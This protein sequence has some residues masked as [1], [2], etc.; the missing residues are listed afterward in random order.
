MVTAVFSES[1]DPLT[2]GTTWRGRLSS[3]RMAWFG[4][5]RAPS[6]RPDGHTE[7]G[8][9]GAETDSCVDSGANCGSCG[10][11]APSGMALLLCTGKAF[12]RVDLC[13]ALALAASGHSACSKYC[14]CYTAG[15][16]MPGELRLHVKT[17]ASLL[18]QK[19]RSANYCNRHSV[20][21]A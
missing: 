18:S 13:S 5:A 14:G 1:H 12:F 11:L 2:S 16:H 15:H 8:T 9:A 7:A 17:P 21:Q 20:M 10:S 3:G 4:S 6:P 19:K